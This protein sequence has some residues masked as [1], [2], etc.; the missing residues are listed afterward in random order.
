MVGFA[1]QPALEEIVRLARK[2]R[3]LVVED[4]GSGC[5]VDLRSAGI[6]G[7]PTVSASLRSGPDV[8]TFSGDKLL[9]GPQ[10]GIILGRRKLLAL[11]RSN[12]LYRALRVDKLTLAALEATLLSYLRG[13]ECQSVPALKMIFRTREQL[14]ERTRALIQRVQ[15]AGGTV[16]AL[17]LE[18]VAGPSLIGGGST[19]GQEIPSCLLAVISKSRSARALEAHLRSGRPPILTRVD[20]NRVLLDLRTVEE[21]EEKEIVQSLISLSQSGKKSS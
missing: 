12:P 15:Q 4:L 7:E 20:G 6:P 3:L 19:P 2:R 5:L 18:L 10:A 9:G 21:G 1:E 8:I 17:S 11:L 16:D 13:E 14:E